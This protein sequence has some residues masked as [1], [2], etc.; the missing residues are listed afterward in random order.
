[1]GKVLPPTPHHTP[2]HADVQMGGVD[3]TFCA[4]PQELHERFGDDEIALCLSQST[5]ALTSVMLTDSS[6]QSICFWQRASQ[7]RC[8]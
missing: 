5:Q 8:G 7:V 4:P 6:V 1:M 2:K 3:C